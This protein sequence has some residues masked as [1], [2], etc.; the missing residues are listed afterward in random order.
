VVTNFAKRQAKVSAT[1]RQTAYRKRQ[2][3]AFFDGYGES[4]NGETGADGN[5]D[6]RV[7]EG[8]KED[9]EAVTNRH[10]DIE[11]DIDIEI[12][13]EGEEEIEGDADGESPL[14]K[15]G[16]RGQR[17][18]GGVQP[19]YRDDI[20]HILQSLEELA[21]TKLRRPVDEKLE[22]W[23]E[24]LIGR[25]ATAADIRAAW[26]WYYNKH[27][28]PPPN[29]Q[30]LSS[31]VVIEMDKRLKAGRLGGYALAGTRMNGARSGEFDEFIQH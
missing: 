7:T 6:D 27:G 11:G 13:E 30:A 31:P 15:L 25:G 26:A 2:R 14:D 1:E 19:T 4:D 22:K 29:P 23:A 10:T 21:G 20:E 28:T 17:A 5:D 3:E 8:N 9:N 18:A 16:V 24:T 12:E